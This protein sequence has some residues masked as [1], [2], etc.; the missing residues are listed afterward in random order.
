MER[1]FNPNF[2]NPRNKCVG[3]FFYRS[4]S[5]YKYVLNLIIHIKTAQCYVRA[6]RFSVYQKINFDIFLTFF[7]FTFRGNFSNVH[8]LLK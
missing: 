1:L 4:N 8:L 3:D 7:V 2:G 5:S 6:K